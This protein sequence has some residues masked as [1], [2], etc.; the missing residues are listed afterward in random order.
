VQDFGYGTRLTGHTDSG[1]PHGTGIRSLEPAPRFFPVFCKVLLSIIYKA[2]LILICVSL[3]PVVDFS[4]YLAPRLGCRLDVSRL[5]TSVYERI[6][7]GLRE[8]TSSRP[9]SVHS[10]SL[11]SVSDTPVG[12]AIWHYSSFDTCSGFAVFR[13]GELLGAFGFRRSSKTGFN[14]VSGV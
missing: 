12:P 5:G 1:P 3:A 10:F 11:K 8:A 2:V 13:L 14:S 4:W 7:N 6:V 9:G